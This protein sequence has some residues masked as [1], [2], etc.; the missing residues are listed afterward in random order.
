MQ[1]A[2]LPGDADKPDL[3][4]AEFVVVDDFVANK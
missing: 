4:E 3:V 1:E 2:Q